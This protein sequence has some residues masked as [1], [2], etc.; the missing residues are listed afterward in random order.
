MDGEGGLR[1]DNT[2]V[3]YCKS[4][5]TDDAFKSAV[6]NTRKASLTGL[7]PPANSFTGYYTHPRA[8]NPN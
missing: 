7:M 1:C 8:R 4:S 3:F 2:R 5:I 6:G